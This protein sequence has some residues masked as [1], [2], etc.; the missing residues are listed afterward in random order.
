MSLVQWLHELA[1]E[2]KGEYDPESGDLLVDPGDGLGANSYAYKE[3]VQ[4]WQSNISP[5]E[6]AD[7]V[8]YGGTY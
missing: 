4:L 8:R 5:R 6:A 1:S 7:V 2:L 3:L